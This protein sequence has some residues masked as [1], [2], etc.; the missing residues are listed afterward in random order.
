MQPVTWTQEVFYETFTFNQVNLIPLERFWLLFFNKNRNSIT[1]NKSIK[2]ASNRVKMKKKKILNWVQIK[3]SSFCQQAKQTNSKKESR[4]RKKKAN[5][6]KVAVQSTIC[7]ENMLFKYEIKTDASKFN[8]FLFHSNLKLICFWWFVSKQII[9][10]Q[11]NPIFF[12][13]LSFSQKW[14]Q[15]SFELVYLPLIN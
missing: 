15:V 11:P 3:F 9:K 5:N 8:S 4:L 12:S 14:Y 7:F 13:F 6:I 2:K 10:E 1:F